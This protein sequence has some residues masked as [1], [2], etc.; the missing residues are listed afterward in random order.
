MR[1]IALGFALFAA[2]CSGSGSGGDGGGNGGLTPT[3]NGACVNDGDTACAGNVLLTCSDKVWGPKDCGTNICGALGN[4]DGIF[5]CKEPKNPVDPGDGGGGGDGAQTNIAYFGQCR[6]GVDSCVAGLVCQPGLNL[7]AAACNPQSTGSCGAAQSCQAVSQTDPTMGICFMQDAQRD[8]ACG[9]NGHD[10]APGQGTC[11]PVGE[12]ALACKVSCTGAEIGTQGSCGAQE[13][14]MA[15]STVE[16]QQPQKA[17]TTPGASTDCDA[18]AGFSCFQVQDGNLCAKRT[19]RCGIAVPMVGDFTQ[20]GLQS[21][22]QAGHTCD[23][24]AGHRYCSVASTSANAA[25]A[26]CVAVTQ[27]AAGKDISICVGSCG[28][29]EGSPDGDCG[30][31][32]ECRRPGVNQ[33]F[34]FDVQANAAGT[35]VTCTK[36]QADAGDNSACNTAGGFSCVGPFSGAAYY[37][38]AP[39]KVCLFAAGGGATHPN[40]PNPI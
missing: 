38:A 39:A 13:L 8:A 15:S 36:A 24:E 12:T 25:V 2:A 37:C 21:A 1:K 31:G 22:V 27:D 18:A 9:D 28:G 34:Y 16:P 7:C 33:A 11:S 32:Y 20:A 5:A 30:T 40:N 4:L 35:Q 10:C 6:P 29:A 3:A 17:C 14:C 19:G 23:D 26:A